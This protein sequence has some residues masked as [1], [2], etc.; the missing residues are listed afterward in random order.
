MQVCER[1]N[2]GASNLAG[3]QSG[4][5]V[6][7]FY[8]TCWCSSQLWL[9]ETEEVAMPPTS[10]LNIRRKGNLKR[11]DKFVLGHAVLGL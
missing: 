7:G 9:W 1:L 4:K 6:L 3:P 2:D 5:S 10:I 11:E 8:K